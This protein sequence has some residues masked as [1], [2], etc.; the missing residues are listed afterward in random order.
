MLDNLLANTTLSLTEV[1]VLLGTA[2]VALAL[3]WLSRG[4]GASRREAELKR[5][6][7]EAKRAI[8]Q[9]ESSVR[10]REQQ[11][12]RLEMQVSELTDQTV[13]LNQEISR[14]ENEGRSQAREIR[15]LTSELSAVK[16]TGHDDP[17][18]LLGSELDYA[19]SAAAPDAEAAGK[20][21]RL[22]ALYDKLKAVLI[23][24][25]DRIAE[26]EALLTGEASARSDGDADVDSS[27]LNLV[28][29]SALDD[30]KEELAALEERNGA[31]KEQLREVQ[32]EKDML[33]DLAKRRSESNRALKSASA[34]AEAQLPQLIAQIETKDETIALREASIKRL[35]DQL[36]DS[37]QDSSSKGDELLAAQEKIAAQQRELDAA[38]R[39]RGEFH[40][41]LEGRD[42]RIK[43][44]SQ[45][46]EI[47]RDSLEEERARLSAR[48]HDLKCLEERME[49]AEQEAERLAADARRNAE[50]LQQALADRDFQLA[51]LGKDIERLKQELADS[52]DREAEAR[53]DA[54]ARESEAEA[55]SASSAQVLANAESHAAERN[56]ALLR[57]IED[58]RSAVSLHEKWMA[59]LKDNLAERESQLTEL[60]ATRGAAEEAQRLAEARVAELEANVRDLNRRLDEERQA[61]TRTLAQRE[62]YAARLHALEAGDPA[63][64]SPAGGGDPE[65]GRDG[66]NGQPAVGALPGP[67]GSDSA[68]ALP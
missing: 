17:H 48:D 61:L 52:R 7:L 50:G 16:G 64:D 8:P 63:A 20:L 6:V 5:E 32:Q 21:Q 60:K 40:Q 53:A 12:S 14:L 57:E 59:K 29:A 58:L 51:A 38:A 4:N 1:G 31:L 15:N 55:A 62:D 65:T 36:E 54:A 39:A 2:V 35:Q 34:E 13:A 42:A 18:G 68:T 26:L 23:E 41:E 47:L 28:D 43:V 11:A 25:D 19:S 67:A 45:E 3:G 30:L 10:N 24:R 27:T 22:E 66:S 37:R 46:Q 49:E 33:E 9:L 56:G 44:L